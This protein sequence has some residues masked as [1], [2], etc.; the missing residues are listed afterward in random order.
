MEKQIIDTSL[1]EIAVY[2]KGPVND[3]LPI[4]FLHGVYFDHHM[5]D[6]YVQ[7]F[8]DRMVI[9]IDMPWHG[10][11][12]GNISARWSLEEC[13]DMLIAILKKLRISSV[14]AIGHSW[15]SMTIL[16]AAVKSPELFASAGYCNMPFQAATRKQKLAF[17]FQHLA[18]PFRTFYTKQAGRSL[19]GKSSLKENP[20]L[21]KELQR[22]MSILSSQQIRLTDT[23]VILQAEDA[24]DTLAELKVPAMALKGQEDYVPAAPYISNEIIPGG[25]IS[26][27][28]QPMATLHFISQVIRL[29]EKSQETTPY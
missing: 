6:E 21:M 25:H 10:E 2:K 20:A 5:W 7:H 23:F 22:S 26:P 4:I 17:R 1:G 18:L 16:R 15:G 28:E 29:A 3:R 13:A 12:R 8:T 9:T 24:S 14:I 19:F 27:L 11:S